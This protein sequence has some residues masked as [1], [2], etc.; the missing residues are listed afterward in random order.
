MR[1]VA[2]AGDTAQ[3]KAT[4][5]ASAV[6]NVLLISCSPRGQALLLPKRPDPLSNAR[7]VP[8]GL[9]KQ[10]IEINEIFSEIAARARSRASIPCRYPAILAAF[11]GR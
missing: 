1:D 5:A 9:C 4:S 11:T 2:A 3:P 7:S 6:R 10:V 8:A